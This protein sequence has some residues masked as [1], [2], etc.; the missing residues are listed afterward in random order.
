MRV[1]CGSYSE[2]MVDIYIVKDVQVLRQGVSSRGDGPIVGD[3]DRVVEIAQL[4]IESDFR[5]GGAG[6]TRAWSFSTRLAL[7]I[8]GVFRARQ[9]SF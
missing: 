7:A 8:E 5:H 1:S 2:A 6:H 3:E 9:S 4:R